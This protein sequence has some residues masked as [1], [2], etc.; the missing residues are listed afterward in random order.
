MYAFSPRFAGQPAAAFKLGLACAVTLLLAGAAAHAT[1]LVQN[2]DFSVNDGAY[3]LGYSGHNVADWSNTGI[4][5]GNGYNFLFLPGSQT[6][7]YGTTSTNSF[8]QYGNLSLYTVT[9]GPSGGNFI[10]DDADFE[11][12]AITQTINGLTVGD[13]YD[14]TF[15]WAAAQQ[16]GFF[17]NG[18]PITQQW[19]VT[20]GGQT[21]STPVY[22]LPGEIQNGP[23]VQNFSGWMPASMNFTASNT[24]ETLSFLAA[25]NPQ[26]PPFTLL[27]DVSMQDT[28]PHN[29][30]V[31]EP[32]T[33]PLLLTGLIVGAGLLKFRGLP[34]RSQQSL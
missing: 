23:T 20:L 28:T 18:T 19:K 31:P 5:S 27:A 4:N 7:G 3:Q 1:E 26:V 11:T 8:G 30:P 6:T 24:S 13:T 33:L 9:G 15:E 34:R 32:Q 2:G 17:F 22:N 21:Q 25:G 10:A 14:L 29:S 12:S 16:T